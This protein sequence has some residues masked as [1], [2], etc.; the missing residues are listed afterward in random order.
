MGRKPM[1]TIQGHFSG[2]WYAGLEM[3]FS[4]STFQGA[5]SLTDHRKQ[6]ECEKNGMR[7]SF[8][9]SLEVKRQPRSQGSL[10]PE[11]NFLAT[12]GISSNVLHSE[13]FR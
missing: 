4:H 3:T 5:V 11:G 8:A 12:C 7:W 6:N 2:L 10:L 1:D 13:Q 9:C